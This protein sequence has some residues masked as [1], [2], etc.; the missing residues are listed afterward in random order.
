MHDRSRTIQQ[1]QQLALLQQ[2]LN[3]DGDNDNNAFL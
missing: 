3:D 1:L 2:V